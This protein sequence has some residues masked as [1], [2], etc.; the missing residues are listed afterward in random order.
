MGKPFDFPNPVFGSVFYL[1]QL[2]IA[3]VSNN[4]LL[5]NK[6]YILFAIISNFGSIY[7]GFILIY[8]LNNLCIVCVTIYVINFLMLLFAIYRFKI[9]TSFKRFK[10]D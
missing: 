2:I 3:N 7:L 8:F 4:N 6:I 9:I 10:K 5:L 1:L